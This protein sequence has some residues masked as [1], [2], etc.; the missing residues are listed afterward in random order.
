[1]RDLSGGKPVG[2]KIAAGNVEADLEVAVKADPDFIT[3]DG[4]GGATGSVMKFIKDTASVPTL[5]ALARAKKFFDKNNIEGI[6]LIVT[7]GLRISSDFIKALALGADAVAIG[8]TALM[9]IGCQQYRICHTGRCPTGI[10][11][12]DPLLRARINIEDSAARLGRFFDATRNELEI[13]TRMSGNRRIKNLS[14]NDL[15]THNPAIAAVTG[16]NLG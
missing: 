9:A 2:V 8:T 11:S 14:I 1:M 4:K 10:T 15:S 6:S 3:I 12:Q 16:I 13:F 5:F 7:G